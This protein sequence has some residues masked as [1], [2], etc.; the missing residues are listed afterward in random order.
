MDVPAADG[1]ERE[2]KVT[3]FAGSHEDRGRMPDS[4]Y[5]AASKIT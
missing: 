5:Q 1:G 3:P 4:E 2:V